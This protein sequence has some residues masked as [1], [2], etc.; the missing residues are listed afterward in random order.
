M[1][2]GEDSG[3]GFGCLL[4]RER[5]ELKWEKRG[6]VMTYRATRNKLKCQGGVHRRV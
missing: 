3:A 5:L 1:R 4:I 6:G 2:E